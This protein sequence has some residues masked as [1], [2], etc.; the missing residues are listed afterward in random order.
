LHL[1]CILH[2]INLVGKKICGHFSRLAIL[3][4]CFWRVDLVVSM[5][6]TA[7]RVDRLPEGAGWPWVAA[8]RFAYFAA[9]E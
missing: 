9:K 3:K 1:F 4:A 5:E 8:P 2:I 6:E 7:R